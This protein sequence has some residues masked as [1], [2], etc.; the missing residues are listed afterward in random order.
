MKV[1]NLLLLAICAIFCITTATFADDDLI[2]EASAP[3]IADPVNPKEGMVFKGYYLDVDKKS[4]IPGALEK[5][6]PV[7]TTVVKTE[8][9]SWNQFSDD[10]K[11]S[12]GLWEGFLKCKRSAVCTIVIKQDNWQGNACILFVNGKKVCSGYG[13]QSVDVEMKAGF[14][15][16]KLIAYNKPVA[17]YL[18]P[19]GSTKDPKLLSPAI[20]F[21]DEKPEEDV[22]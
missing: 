2:A 12:H 15:H 17:M 7:K 3:S 6:A 8:Y 5:A 14:N 9:F 20:M 21:H 18:S 19:K 4:E 16:I 10:T 11:I 1:Y 22:I 13:Q